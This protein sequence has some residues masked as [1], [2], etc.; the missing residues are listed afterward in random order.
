[1]HAENPIAAALEMNQ[2]WK[3]AE[4]LVKNPNNDPQ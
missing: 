1:M 3:H 2:K 4:V